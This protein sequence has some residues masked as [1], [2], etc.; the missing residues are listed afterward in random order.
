[1]SDRLT[2]LEESRSCLMPC[3]TSVSVVLAGVYIM[4]STPS[5]PA[6]CVAILTTLHDDSYAP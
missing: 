4:H 1:M 5:P 6:E 2:A 3:R